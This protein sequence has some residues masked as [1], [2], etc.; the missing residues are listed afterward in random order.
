MSVIP[1]NYRNPVYHFRGASSY[2]GPYT[3]TDKALKNYGVARELFGSTNVILTETSSFNVKDYQYPVASD[4]QGNVT[5]V[6]MYFLPVS[7][8]SFVIDPNGKPVDGS[9]MVD[10]LIRS[11]MNLQPTDEIYALI[12]YMHPELN[13]GTIAELSTTDKN[14]LG[15]THLGAYLGNGNTSNSPVAYHDHRFGCDPLQGTIYGYPCN[16]HIVGLSGADQATF[17]RNCNLVDML[18]GHGLEFPGDYQNSMFRPVYINAALM[19]YRDWLN[20]EPYLMND[21]TWYFYCAANKLTILNIACN[22]PHNPAS[23]KEV[24]GETEGDQLWKQFLNRYRNVTGFDFYYYKGLETNFTP[25]WK[26][27]GLT[28]ADIVPFTLDQYNAYDLAYRTGGPYNGPAPTLPP[29]AVV[30]SPQSTADVI[31]EFEQIYADAYDAGA[32]SSIG[33]I[34]GFK[35]AALNRTGIPELE[36]LEY[37]L[38]IFQLLA[39]SEAQ[40]YATINPV[41]NWSDSPWLWQTYNI[42]IVIF[43]GKPNPDNTP[44]NQQQVKDQVA[45]PIVLQDAINAAMNPTDTTPET[46]AIYTLL[47]VANNWTALMQGGVISREDAYDEYMQGATAIFDAAK[48]VVVSQPNKIQYNILPAA[49]NLINNGLYDKNKFVQVQT[50]CTAVDMSEIELKKT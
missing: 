50:I 43:G 6:G 44:Q 4:G 27:E 23:F 16:V 3:I 37:V 2:P 46:L 36:Y 41:P 13:Q 20:Q 42:L 39:Y 21:S 30:C 1:P 26:L 25:L 14:Q 11:K 8:N 5:A 18:V 17:N 33:V 45:K 10:D 9:K 19:Y 32:L 12:S 47:K 15:F 29:K 22:L 24:Y 40:V 48:K 31:Y 34:W 28:A 38:P 49:F 35:D 7:N